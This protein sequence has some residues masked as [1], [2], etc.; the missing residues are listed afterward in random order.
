MDQQREQYENLKW[1]LQRKLEE[2]EGELALQRQVSA[3]VWPLLG[4]CAAR[5][6]SRRAGEEKTAFCGLCVPWGQS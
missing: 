3:R 2:L 5:P 6:C 1:Q 4:V